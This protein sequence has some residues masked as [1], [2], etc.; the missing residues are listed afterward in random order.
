MPTPDGSI[1]FNASALLVDV[2]TTGRA[3]AALPTLERLEAAAAAS[4]APWGDAIAA[5][6]RALLSAA[7][8][9]EG[10]YRDAIEVSVEYLDDQNPNQL[11]CPS[12]PQLCQLAGDYDSLREV[13]RRRGDM[14]NFT[15][16]AIGK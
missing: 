10:R 12:L 11:A 4:R 16:A 1:P 14:L 9:A 7:D 2:F 13:A 3:D 8:D 15:A 5:R 6:S